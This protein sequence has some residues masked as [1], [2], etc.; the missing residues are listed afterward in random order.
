MHFWGFGGCSLKHKCIFCLADS[1]SISD[2]L[3]FWCWYFQHEKVWGQC[4][5]VEVAILFLKKGLKLCSVNKTLWLFLQPKLWHWKNER[6]ICPWIGNPGKVACTFS[7]NI[8]FNLIWIVIYSKILN[9]CEKQSKVLRLLAT[10]YL[11]WDCQR[12]QE[13]ALNAVNLANKVGATVTSRF[14]T[15]FQNMR[16]NKSFCLFLG[17]YEHFC[18]VLEDQDSLKMWGLRWRHQGRLVTD[19]TNAKFIL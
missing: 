11:E 15:T 1:I 12:F 8:Q 4:N 2:V 9:L 3:Q 10:V 13:K 17:V 5:L 18:A 14:T 16:K 6:K 19:I 7:V